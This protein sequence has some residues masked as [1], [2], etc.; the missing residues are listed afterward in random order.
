MTDPLLL[1]L[2]LSLTTARL[3]LRPPQAGDGPLFQAAL[4]ESLPELRRYLGALPWIACDHTTES[5]ELYCRN[6]HANFV[7]RKDIPYFIF[8][9]T[10]GQLVGG[11][12]LH[13][14]VWA[15]PKAEVGYWCRTASAGKGFVSEAVTALAGLAFHQLG[16]VRLELIT[17]QANQAS[18][19]VAERCGF[20][21]EGTLRN[22]SR[23]PDGTLR[24]MCVYARLPETGA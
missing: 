12:G 7:A 19:R 10:T 4:A 14:A 16:L 20:T 2:P 24:N 8:D 22:E 13:R 23:A 21:L 5:A 15:T 9:Q 11:I 1:V 18:R 3:T 17:D 6:A